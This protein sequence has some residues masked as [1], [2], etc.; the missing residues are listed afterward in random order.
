MA[1]R[2]FLGQA[3]E[4]AFVAFEKPSQRECHDLANNV[5]RFE[6]FCIIEASFKMPHDEPCGSVRLVV[7]PGC[8]SHDDLTQRD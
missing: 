2:Y 7:K 5:R 1:T 6:D 3:M 4:F 8:F